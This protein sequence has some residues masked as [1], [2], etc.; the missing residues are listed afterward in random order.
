M[1]HAHCEYGDGDDRFELSPGRTNETENNAAVHW[2]NA[3]SLFLRREND[4]DGDDDHD[5]GDDDHDDD[6][7]ATIDIHLLPDVIHPSPDGYRRWFHEINKTI[8]Q[9][10]PPT[11]QHTMT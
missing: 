6:N 7:D 8:A 9:L 3:T 5:G 11:T 4:G 1:V 10:I 2:F